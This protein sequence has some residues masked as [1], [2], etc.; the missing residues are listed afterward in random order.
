MKQAPLEFWP[1]ASACRCN[2]S[3]PLCAPV[4]ARVHARVCA[5]GLFPQNFHFCLSSCLLP[6]DERC[7]K[8]NS[9]PRV[10]EQEYGAHGAVSTPM[11]LGMFAHPTDAMAAGCAHSWGVH[12]AVAGGSTKHMNGDEEGEQDGATAGLRRVRRS[13]STALTRADQKIKRRRSSSLSSKLDTLRMETEHLFAE[14]AACDA[15]A[16]RLCTPELQQRMIELE[17]Q[18]LW[19]RSV[20]LIISVSNMFDVQAETLMHAISLLFRVMQVRHLAPSSDRPRVNTLS[21]HVLGMHS[22][23]GAPSLRVHHT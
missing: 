2:S 9:S 22:R 13:P 20:A 5:R 16:A 10:A 14:A 1:A 6:A 12:G 17:Q 7:G 3:P 8:Q 18:G 11:T 4:H 21:C 23:V 15:R 19:G